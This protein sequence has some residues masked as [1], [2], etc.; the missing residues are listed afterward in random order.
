MSY[1]H[2]PFLY[3]DP[4]VNNLITMGNDEPTSPPDYYTNFGVDYEFEIESDQTGMLV[5]DDHI[6]S[7]T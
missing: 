2:P 6:L 7:I 5:L 4:I 1:R 3:D